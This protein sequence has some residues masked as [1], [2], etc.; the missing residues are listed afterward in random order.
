MLACSALKRAYREI[1]T[2]PVVGQSSRASCIFVVLNGSETVIRE[3]M[4]GREHFM[5]PGLLRSQFDALELPVPEEGNR[6]VM[7]EDIS[8]PV[9]SLVKSVL[10]ELETVL[11][12]L[13]THGAV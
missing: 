7:V 13:P 4:A 11:T 10:S 5:P 8:P 6:L 2:S 1:L 12:Q 9:Q 3:R